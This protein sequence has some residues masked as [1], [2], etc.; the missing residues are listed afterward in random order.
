MTPY[1]I[2]VTPFTVWLAPVGTAFPVVTAEPSS[3]WF[4]LGTNGNRNY[5]EGGVTVAHSRS[6]NKIRTAG[7]TGPIKASLTE[8]DVMVRLTLLDMTL[9]QYTYALNNNT[10]TTTAA[11]SG[12][13]GTK[14]IGL[15]EGVNATREF[16]LLARGIS[17]Y[18][19]A[20]VAQYELGR[21]FSSGNAEPVFRKGEPAALALE[22]TALELASATAEERL[23]RFIEQHQAPLE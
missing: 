19:E 21:V 4:K 1:E 18:D 5:E 23:G 22:F 13:A 9:E 15:S 8:E 12:T 11:G 16:A 7:A 10:V 17:A 14:K 3:P 6:F 20:M 2:L